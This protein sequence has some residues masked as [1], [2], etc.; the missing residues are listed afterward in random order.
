MGG[1]KLQNALSLREKAEE[2]FKQQKSKTEVALSESDVLRLV[3]E[4][5]VYQIEHELIIDELTLQ[6]KVN[7]QRVGD[8]LRA[9]IENENL[10]K[11]NKESTNKFRLI[12]RQVPGVVYQY[13]L[14][15]DGSSC[16]P[17]TSEGINKVYRVTP[18]EVLEDASKV[19]LNIH[20]DD[21]EGVA[22]S[23]QESAKNLTP[24]QHEYRVKFDDGSI[25]WLYGD[26]LPQLEAD[27]SI[28]W[29]GF[30]TDISGRKQTEEVL[31]QSEERYRTVTDHSPLGSV[32][33]RN[34]MIV[35]ANPA[36]FLM[37][38]ASSENELVGTSIFVWIH[39]DFHQLSANRTLEVT[40]DS[41]S[42]QPIAIQF[43]RPDGKVCVAEVQST[44]IMY[45]EMPAIHVA[46]ND[47]TQR[48]E[49][50][51]KLRQSEQKYQT[52]VESA[53]VGILVAQGEGLKFVNPNFIELSGYSEPE[54]LSM[55]F[56][57]LVYADDQEAILNA[58]RRRL[59]DQTINKS[60]RLRMVK[61]DK[62][63]IWLALRSVRID[64]LGEPASLNFVSDID[65]RIKAESK[66]SD[67]ANRLKIANRAGGIGIWDFDV[68]RNII[69]WDDKMYELYG[70]GKES[71]GGAYESWLNAVHPDDAGKAAIAIT[72][73][74]TGEK[75]YDIEFRVIWPDGSIH[76]LKALGE[77]QFNVSG[78]AYRMYGTNY[79]ITAQKE[80]EESLN[81]ALKKSEA[82]NQ[83]KSEFLTNM[84]HEIRTP[85]NGV[86]GFTDL[87]LTTSLDNA[88]QQY[89]RN[90][91]ISGHSL[92][93]IINDILDYIKIEGGEMK[94]ESVKTDLINLVELKSDVIN[95]Y[96]SQKGLEL[97]VNIQPDTPRYIFTD[98]EK[99]KRILFNLLG[100]A[101]KFTESG[102][103]EL[104][105]SF[106]KMDATSGELSFSVRDTG[107]GISNEEQKRLFKLFSQADNST[108]R[109]Y[110]GIGLGLMI[111]NSMARLMGSEIE[112]SSVVGKGSTFSFKLQADY[113]EEEKFDRNSLGS[114]HRILLID[115]NLNSRFIIEQMV[116][117]W[118]FD[119]V[120][121]EGVTSAIKLLESS[122]PF[123]VILVDYNMPDLNG[124]DTI[125]M[126]RE[127]SGLVS[128]NQP[129]LLL[130]SSL[131]DLEVCEAYQKMGMVINLY[132]PLK[133]K[134]FLQSLK[135][136]SD[137]TA[138]RIECEIAVPEPDL[139]WKSAAPVIL[140]AEDELINMILI[141]ELVK[142]IIPGA[143]ILKAKNGREAYE[144][145][146]SQTPNL[147]IMDIQM[148][149][150][151]GIEA[152]V[153][154]RNYEKKHGGHI[155]IVALTA[156]F[157]REKC[158]EA[159]MDR[160]IP[161]P[162]N[163]KMLEGLL[164]NLWR[165][166]PSLQ[167]GVI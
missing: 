93:G 9:N 62:S 147:I 68:I 69:K 44:P 75:D 22:S 55:S 119:F 65:D 67:L 162:L 103:V 107:I 76:H 117:R 163:P 121:I 154:I 47:I 110:G 102:E 126:I 51:R 96:A 32:V 116:T 140:I 133:S 61:K 17:Y 87:L 72:M 145:A 166:F 157:E 79:D 123:D 164:S 167:E 10:T 19:F 29:H 138:G 78:K 13:R 124:I 108:T 1:G 64:W 45:D 139:T 115:D 98:P 165:A 136:I 132:K 36:A 91:N 127:Q 39:P 109:K 24:W 31:R 33:H 159:G 25:N 111:S 92:L 66:L 40:R 43:L 7:E 85:L 155:P 28:L 113:E 97:L 18:E 60:I 86:I 83:A 57:D 128:E 146:V 73:A 38:G 94:P 105:V 50:E 48:S 148:S 131:N 11:L 118:G 101:V 158:L 99:L 134:E 143:T 53:S 12:A 42:T 37:M 90:A 95:Y 14:G 135:N 52:L 144:M 49:F 15:P 150:M 5:E 125:T 84:S 161:K 6:N 156:G 88:Q 21:L 58:Y 149:E 56:L 151:S 130:H 59:T 81:I 26:A 63:M 89:A 77:V 122:K 27:G 30:T 4:L 8:L 16:F 137:Q 41:V 129:F 46:L 100:N 54:L 80:L 20:P 74:V 34:G 3:H 142:R 112:L 141:I 82:A 104:K 152:S 114:I 71:F 106:T 70:F 153:E 120:G 23:I 160:F 35:Y 2:L